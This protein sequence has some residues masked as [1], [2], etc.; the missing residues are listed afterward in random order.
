ML[1]RTR[2]DVPAFDI[3]SAERHDVL[4]RA[5]TGE[6]QLARRTILLDQSTVLTHN[7]GFFM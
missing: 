5:E 1:Y 3:L 2:G 7:I 4:R 6:L